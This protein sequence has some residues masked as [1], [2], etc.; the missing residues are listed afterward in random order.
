[1]INELEDD[2]EV[3]VPDAPLQDPDEFFAKNAFRMV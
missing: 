3:S 2:P 1:V